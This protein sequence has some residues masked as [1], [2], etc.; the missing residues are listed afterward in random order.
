[1]QRVTFVRYTTKP[2]QAARNEALCRAV[3]DELRRSG[4]ADVA[5]ALFRDAAGTGFV[6]VFLNFAEDESA[7]VTDLPAFRAFQS[8]I[9][10]RCDVPPEAIRLGLSLVDSYGMHAAHAEV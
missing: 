2:E 10:E 8:G 1:M 3:F 5:Y 4:P 9:S 6:H 7:P